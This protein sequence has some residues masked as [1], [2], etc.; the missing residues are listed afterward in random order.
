MAT[1]RPVSIGTVLVLALSLTLALPATA[2]DSPVAA[3]EALLAKLASGD[4]ATLD[5]VV[6]A[7]QAEA[8]RAQFDPASQLEDL[9]EGMDVEELLSSL[10]ISIE[11]GAVELISEEG[12][13]ATVRLT[14]NMSF[15]FLGMSESEAI[16][17]EVEVVLED[18]EW[19]VCGDLGLGGSGTSEPGGFVSED[20]LCAALTIDEL[21]AL[22]PL[23]Y[24]SSFS[25]MDG[26]TYQSASSQAGF[27]NVSLSIGSGT[28]EQWRQFFSG[29]VDLTVAG[30]PAYS[31]DSQLFVELPDEE[32]LTVSPFVDEETRPEGFDVLA[33]ATQIAEIALPRVPDVERFDFG[34]FDSEPFEQPQPIEEVDLCAALT[35]EELNALSPQPFDGVERQFSSCTY[36]SSDLASGFRVVSTSLNPDSTLETFAMFFPDGEEL[37][38]ADHSA[39]YALEQLFVEVDGEVFSVAAFI[40]DGSGEGDLT[41][42]DYAVQIA[43]IVVPRLPGLAASDGTESTGADTD[44]SLCD[45]IGLDDVN[46]L[47]LTY[48]TADGDATSCDFTTS[49]HALRV[50]IEEADLDLV[51]SAFPGGSDTTVAGRAAYSDGRSLWVALDAGILTVDPLFALSTA[52]EGLDRVAYATSVAELVLERLASGQ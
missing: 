33:Y 6:C 50:L 1:I 5:E 36:S 28:L 29:G 30:S 27:Y 19:L 44:T 31:A 24:D 23:Q 38:V 22:S 32:V 12:E 2:A 15:S 46:T 11:D 9:P 47:G 49:Q 8:V 3:G 10:E 21:N 34:S 26:C 42:R 41:N 35:L 25:G 48:D 16:D 39:Y 18:G 7:A 43:E 40:D 51:R 52:P 14:G 37:T 17:E 4:Y 20:G 13:S 45:L